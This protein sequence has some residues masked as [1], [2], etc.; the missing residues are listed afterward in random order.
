MTKT[1]RILAVGLMTLVHDV[2]TLEQ[3]DALT[4]GRQG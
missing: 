4:Q 2:P 1:S 3:A